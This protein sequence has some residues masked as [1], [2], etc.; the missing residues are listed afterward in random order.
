M[1]NL[2][3][4]GIEPVSPALA[5]GFIREVPAGVLILNAFPVILHLC[6]PVLM[7]ANF[8]I[9]F[10]CGWLPTFIA[11]LS[12]PLSFSFHNF[13]ISSCG[14]FCLQKFLQHLLLSW[15]LPRGLTPMSTPPEWLPQVFTSSHTCPSTAFTGDV[16]IL[17]GKCGPLSYEVIAF[18]LW[19]LSTWGP[20]CT[21][22]EWSFYFPQSRGIP[23]IK[24]H[25]F[26][27]PHSLGPH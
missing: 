21:L 1:W 26:S 11:C 8:D 14:L 10:V 23:A 9:V 20:V 27:R 25:L 18:F 4:P 24:S 12:L 19:L 5:G 22:W 13:L 7:T 17:A 3:T 15:S 16:P 2:P 6:S